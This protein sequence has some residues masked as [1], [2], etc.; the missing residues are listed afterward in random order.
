VIIPVRKINKASGAIA[1]G[2]LSQVVEAGGIAELANLA[3]SFNGMAAQLEISFETLEQR[4]EE[5]T[6][7]LAVAKEKAEAANN[8]KSTFI[9]NMSH[10]LRSPLNAIMGFS[11]LMQHTPDLPAEQYENAGIIYRSGDY[12][13]TLINNILDLS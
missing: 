4:V 1:K 2:E 9:A 5:R 8:A 10:E 11:Q 7:E 6:T 3:Q 12:L 13:L